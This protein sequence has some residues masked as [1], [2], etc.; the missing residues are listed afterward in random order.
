MFPIVI[1][2]ELYQCS[3]NNIKKGRKYQGAKEMSW[4]GVQTFWQSR[5]PSSLLIIH[6]EQLVNA[7]LKT[8]WHKLR[9]RSW[10]AVFW[11]NLTPGS[12]GTGQHSWRHFYTNQSR[13]LSRNQISWV[14][15]GEREVTVHPH[16]ELVI[17]N[18]Y[19]GPWHYISGWL[20]VEYD[21]VS[22]SM[23]SLYA[24]CSFKNDDKNT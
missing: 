9:A 12:E 5:V 4:D 3:R 17:N 24:L 1:Y 21:Q 7:F 8:C 2:G 18:F 19:R 20:S 22:F 15:E 6:V 11:I 14:R 23:L 13:L 10:Q 16:G